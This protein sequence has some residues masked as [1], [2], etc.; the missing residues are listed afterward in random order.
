MRTVVVVPTYQERGSIDELVARTRRAAPQAHLLVVD[1]GSPDGTAEVVEALA[2]RDPSLHLLRRRSKDGLGA[3]YRAGFAW[4]REA[5]FEAVVEMDADLSHPPE[6]V[7]DL[8]D[9]LDRADLVIGS[10]YVP[11]GR[12]AGWPW[13]RRLISRGGNTYVRLAL[14]VSTQDA[15]AGFR[16]F[17]M[18]ALEVIDV[19]GLRSN[20]YCFQVETAYEAHRAGLRVLEHPITF[21]ERVEGSSKMS[22]RIVAEAL[23]RVTWWGLRDRLLRVDRRA[24][25]RRTATPVVAP[26]HLAPARQ[27]SVVGPVVATLGVAVLVGLLAGCGSGTGAAAVAPPTADRA[28]AATAQAPDPSTGPA[29][30][31]GS[32]PSA[33]DAAATE[34]SDERLP[35][36]AAPISPPVGLSIPAIGVEAPVSSLGVGPDGA[37]E[38]PD[39]GDDTGWLD[40]SSLPGARGP[41]VLLG[42]VDSAAGPGVFRDLEQLVV[43]DLIQVRTES[44]ATVDYTVTGSSRYPKTEFPTDLVYGPAPGPLLRL[45]T[46][47]GVFDQS[48]G[49]HLDNVVVFAVRA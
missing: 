42:H 25:R 24:R 19:T 14:G 45:I 4:A 1:D 35:A 20:G 27:L 47:G 5:G 31:T 38:V 18:R 3:A 49:S 15:T 22:G 44:G 17:R 41:A 11:G 40:S 46:C 7:P 29:G 10:R 26:R 32:A 6:V 12:T 23:A 28:V 2:E 30:G 43:G 48:V 16:A 13:H 34:A 33:A 9:G 37:V 21:V 8:I 36:D 39:N